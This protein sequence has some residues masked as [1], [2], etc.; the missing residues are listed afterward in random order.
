MPNKLYGKPVRAAGG[1]GVRV[2][3]GD[4]TGAT[5]GEPGCGAVGTLVPVVGGALGVAI[6]TNDVGVAVVAWVTEAG[7]V[8]VAGTAVA[9]VTGTRGVAVGVGVTVGV[10]VAVGVGVMVGVAVAVG[11]GEGDGVGVG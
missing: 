9:V 6:V 7:A 5:I 2:A 8:G 3:V 11:V 1:A 4:T 10:A